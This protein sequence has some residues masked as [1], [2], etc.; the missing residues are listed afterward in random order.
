MYVVAVNNVNGK[1]EYK[2]VKTNTRKGTELGAIARH[3][4]TACT[5]AVYKVTNFDWEVLGTV[6]YGVKLWGTC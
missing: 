2:Y 6:I 5:K 4:A 3:L 1:E